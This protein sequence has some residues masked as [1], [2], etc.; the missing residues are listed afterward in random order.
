MINV[1]T[2]GNAYE[3]AICNELKTFFPAAITSRNGARFEDSR[4]I[5]VI[6]TGMFN[7]QTKARQA[8][9]IFN[10]LQK[11]M[12]VDHNLNVIF[13]KRDRQKDIICIDKSDFY[14]LLQMLKNEK[15]I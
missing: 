9:N 13:W 10:V 4:G 2:K 7:V 11:E 1:R 8:L 14:E 12:P 5:D 6:N 15:V 3:R